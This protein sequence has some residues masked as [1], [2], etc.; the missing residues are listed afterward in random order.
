MAVIYVGRTH[1][2]FIHFQESP[3]AG[4]DFAT[5]DL[6][7][8]TLWF[9]CGFQE[10]DIPTFYLIKSG[11]QVKE[12]G[13]RLPITFCNFFFFTV[14]KLLQRNRSSKT[15][16][17]WVDLLTALHV[18]LSFPRHTYRNHNKG[19]HLLEIKLWFLYHHHPPCS[20]NTEM[21]T[22][23]QLTDLLD[24]KVCAAFIDR[25]Q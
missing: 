15:H 14:N 8:L 18:I 22:L 10:Q 23:K 12:L 1:I 7:L 25:P 21:D 13:L 17:R 20:I 24:D 6:K 9:V 11:L 3:D 2:N 16:P 4:T 5:Q 19:Q